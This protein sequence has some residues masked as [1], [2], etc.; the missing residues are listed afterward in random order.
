MTGH[1]FGAKPW[2][3]CI[4]FDQAFLSVT[5]QDRHHPVLLRELQFLN[6][7]LF[8]LFFGGQ[9]G[10]L[11]K[12]FKPA[13]ELQM[14]LVKS[15]QFLIVVYMLADEL[16]FSVLHKASKPAPCAGCLALSSAS[17]GLT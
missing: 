7:L 4:D 8:H 10:L 14:L 3:R 13:L 16:F 15:L 17:D 11:S 2:I 6:S 12:G 1:R 5:G 9:V